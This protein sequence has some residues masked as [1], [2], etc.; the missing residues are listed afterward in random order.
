MSFRCSPDKPAR[1]NEDL[2]PL[3]LEVRAL[4]VVMDFG[5]ETEIVVT[6]FGFS[7]RGVMQVDVGGHQT[8]LLGFSPSI[9][10]V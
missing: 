8:L 2:L 9:G 6:T 3:G 7:E 5:T 4:P 1:I 10:Y